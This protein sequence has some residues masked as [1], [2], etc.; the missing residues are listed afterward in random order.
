MHVGD[1]Q[2]VIQASF[3]MKNEWKYTSYILMKMYLLYMNVL[4]TM[5]RDYVKIEDTDRDTGTLGHL[6]DA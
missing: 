5:F 4:R 6:N 2:N 1:L 3:E